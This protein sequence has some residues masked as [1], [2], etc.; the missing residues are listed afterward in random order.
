MACDADGAAGQQA[1]LPRICLN[2]AAEICGD[3]VS[4]AVLDAPPL[5]FG[6]AIVSSASSVALVEATPAAGSAAPSRTSSIAKL[7]FANLGPF[8]PRDA[9]W[10]YCKG[11]WQISGS[12]FYFLADL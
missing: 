2:S 11:K 4:T 10:A 5:T 7:A 8:Q 3:P 9:P 1:G 12:H 6:V